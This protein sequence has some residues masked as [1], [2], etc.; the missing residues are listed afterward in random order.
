M[1]SVLHNINKNGHKICLI[2]NSSHLYDTF[3]SYVNFNTHIP[4][5]V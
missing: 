2:S 5:I 4:I 3:K 1:V